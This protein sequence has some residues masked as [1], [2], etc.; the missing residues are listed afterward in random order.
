MLPGSIAQRRPALPEGFS[1]EW[2]WERILAFLAAFRPP[3]GWL[4]IV[5]LA[6][7][8]STIVWTVERADWA[9]TPNLIYI[10]LMGMLVGLVL[11]RFAPRNAA[12]AANRGN[13]SRRAVRRLD[14]W[15]ILLL[16]VGL[17]I[18]LLTVVWQMVSYRGEGM[19]LANAGQLWDRLYL[20]YEA[21]RI[22]SINIDTVPFAFGLVSASWLSGFLAAWVFFRY[23]NFWGVFILGG[24]GVMSNLTY[25]PDTASTDLAVYLLT[26]LLLVG[27]VQSVRR[28]QEWQR[29][30]FQY[31]SHLG[32]LAISDTVM[33]SMAVLVVA[34]LLPSGSMWTPAHQVYERLRSPMVAWEEDFNRLFAGLPARRALPYRI[35]GDSVAFQGT[36]NPTTTP[37]LQVNSPVAMYWKAR[38]YGTYTNKGW[39]SADTVFKTTDWSP[40][41]STSAPYL[42]RFGVT[43]AITPRYD[44]RNV[45]AAGQVLG[46]DREVLVE[47]YDSPV[48]KIDMNGLPVRR[49]LHPTLAAAKSNLEGAIAQQGNSVANSSLA[50]ALPAGLELTGVERNQGIIESVTFAEVI[51]EQPDTL[52][53]RSAKGNVEPG[54]TYQVTSSVS[55]ATPQRLRLAGEDYPIWALEKYTQRPDNLPPRIGELAGRITEGHNTPYD[56]AKAVETYLKTSFKYNLAIDPPPFNADGVDY[57]LFEQREG[58]SEYFGSAMTVL[59]RTQGIP[60]RLVTGYTVGNKLPEHDLYIVAD[61]HSH[62]WS[63]VYFPTYGWIP[64]EPTPGSSIPVVSIPK[65]KEESLNLPGELQIFDELCED[66]EDECDPLSQVERTQGDD[67]DADAVTLARLAARFFPWIA[68]GLG[69]LVVLGAL[70]RVFWSRYLAPSEEPGDAFR[71]LGFLGRLNAVGVIE[72]QTPYQ[73]EARLGEA[74]PEQRNDLA[75]IIQCYVRSLYGRKELTDEEREGL[76]QA[77]RN[78]RFPMLFHVMSRRTNEPG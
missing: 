36:I 8:L 62:A 35:W 22:G 68:G 12:F 75:G 48:Y 38:S 72:E 33:I 10:I 39:I 42:Q 3:D 21:A 77:W 31:D 16:P 64:F 74:F 20:W 23:R 78:V 51:P 37:V 11:S 24:A 7:N 27:R 73:Y 15:A 57:F 4:S 49:D 52:S 1:G 59:L 61:S 67:A 41:Y 40:E 58:Y 25:L 50:Q 9:P 2:A 28:R 44:S 45:F 29:R 60:A 43:Y 14:W 47:T 13:L 63:E 70:V 6:L 76:V 32:L 56:K 46:V 5:F 17:A 26:A 18:G 54:E 55:L 65:P 69:G 34:Y 53:V 30:N 71:R 19:E 66:D